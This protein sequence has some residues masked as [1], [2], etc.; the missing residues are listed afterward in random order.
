MYPKRITNVRMLIRVESR[1]RDRRCAECC[2]REKSSSFAAHCALVQSA[3]IQRS[4]A[5]DSIID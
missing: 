1:R 3:W 4:K 2:S 5:H